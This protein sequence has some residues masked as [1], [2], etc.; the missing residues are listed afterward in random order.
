MLTFLQSKIRTSE[1]SKKLQDDYKEDF[2]ALEDRIEG[3]LA[4]DK[5]AL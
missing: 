3:K 4:E 2:Q 1:K 5:Q